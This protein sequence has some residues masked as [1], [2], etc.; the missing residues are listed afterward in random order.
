MSGQWQQEERL[1]LHL[2]N[3]RETGG[4]GRRYFS[5]G[6]VKYALLELLGGE[7]MHGYQ[8][9][10]ALEE[11]SGGTYKPSAGSIYPTLQMLRDQGFVEAYKQDGKKIFQITEDGR[12]YL[13]EENE[14]PD[15]SETCEQRDDRDSRE[16]THF[17]EEKGELEGVKRNRRLTPKGKELLHL[18]KAAERAALMDVDKAVKLRELLSQLHDSLRKITS[19]SDRKEAIND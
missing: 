7:N 19:E 8:M 16:G 12:A 2:G 18:L 4:S 5:R 17:D 11:Q 1:F 3:E 10:K 13:E 15:P 9:M 14:R 6:G